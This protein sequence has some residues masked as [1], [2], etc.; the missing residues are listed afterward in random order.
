MNGKLK[1]NTVLVDNRLEGNP[2]V[3]YDEDGGGFGFWPLSVL[4][5]WRG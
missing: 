2:A 1:E 3:Y 4:N 5:I